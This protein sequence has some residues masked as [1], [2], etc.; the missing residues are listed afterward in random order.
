MPSI[1]ISYATEDRPRAKA[2]HDGLEAAGLDCW[3]APEDIPTGV[4]WAAA[5]YEAIR[6]S[7]AFVLVFSQSS[8]VSRDVEKELLLATENEI[9]VLP[10]LLEEIKPAPAFA[11]HLL[12]IQQLLAYQMSAEE[13]LSTLQKNIYRRVPSLQGAT[14]QS[15]GP[16]TVARSEIAP[17]VA[18][19]FTDEIWDMILYFIDDSA[20]VPI[21][22]P[23]LL[24]VTIDGRRINLYSYLAKCLAERLE[25]P[26]HDLPTTGALREV[27]SRWLIRK[28][29]LEYLYSTLKGVFPR[30]DQLSL[31]MPLRQL[32]KI[33]TLKLFVTT[34]FDSLLRRTLD[35]ERFGGNPETLALS[36]S[37]HLDASDLDAPLDSID[38]PVVFH[39]FGHLSAF[40][41]YVVTEED[42]VE[43]IHS[44]VSTEGHPTRLRGELA[45]RTILLLGGN[46]PDWIA[47]SLIRFLQ[48]GRDR[49][50]IARREV[51]IADGYLCS[52]PGFLGY[53]QN[54]STPSRIYQEGG[55]VEFVDQLFR[56]WR[57]RHPDGHGGSIPKA[58]PG[59]IYISFAS[60]DNEAVE[61]L[62]SGL[63]EEGLDAWIDRT[64]AA[65]DGWE[66]TV[67]HNLERC[68][69]FIPILSRHSLTQAP[70]F[71]RA[72]WDGAIK[73]AERMP[74]SRPF[75]L[76]V[77]IDDTSPTDPGLPELFRNQHWVRLTPHG[78]SP[79]QVADLKRLVRDYRRLLAKES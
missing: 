36:Y 73:I 41:D 3:I 66:N 6:D 9:P 23:E 7:R 12:N 16:P 28:G 35:E 15:E 45:H 76:P 33:P 32:A 74:P 27:A 8:N 47:R 39:L 58:P 44:L 22:G 60:E 71:F 77:V 42:T 13:A 11:Y 70:R 14:S 59:A 29:E 17:L 48:G 62:I 56:R 40:P 37:P 69:L 25:I 67:R 4:S 75:I 50:R 10:Y 63:N 43:A 26:S 72:E 24:D 30:S 61:L 57:E 21:V 38:R 51:I 78:I 64:L 68:S 55:A 53:V 49:L 2:I 79:E 34:T 65:G 52:D 31:P 5:I 46:L 1:F 54:S 20:V 19:P 18:P